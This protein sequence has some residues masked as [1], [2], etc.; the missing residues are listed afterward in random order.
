M[1]R[2]TKDRLVDWISNMTTASSSDS[3]AQR[4]ILPPHSLND[5]DSKSTRGRSSSA[6]SRTNDSAGDDFSDSIELEP[7]IVLQVETDNI[8]TPAPSPMSSLS[9]SST[10]SRS[11]LEAA[12]TLGSSG[13]ARPSVDAVDGSSCLDAVERTATQEMRIMESKLST[14][15][16]RMV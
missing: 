9:R 8:T 4:S 13:S 12:S 10:S 3:N 14:L 15:E 1:A 11:S 16:S 2:H 5:T 6:S 7:C